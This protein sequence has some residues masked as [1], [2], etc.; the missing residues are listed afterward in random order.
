MTD[1]KKIM[2][3]IP[4]YDAKIAVYGM[5]SLISA[6][7]LLERNGYKVVFWGQLGCCYLDQT[8]NHI[9]DKFLASDCSH[10]I[11][12]DSDLSFDGDAIIKLLKADEQIVAAA[13]PYRSLEK[14]GFPISIKLDEN[15]IPIGNRE[16]HL[17]ECSF[18]PTGLMCIKRDVF[19]ILKKEYPDLIDSSGELQFFQT[20]ILFAK[21]GNKDY[22]GEDVYFCE[23][24]KRA[25]IQI[26]CDP[27]INIDH[28]GELHR[29]GNYD[30]YL[31]TAGAGNVNRKEQNGNRA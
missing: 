16:K 17:I 29:K 8:R 19:D 21:E 22:Y 28:I 5:F 15:R 12:V 1:P 25:G 23:I 3:A 11:M 7:I 30:Q 10:L 9:V 2:I 6:V 18:V 14:E 24:C 31:R 26:W 4:S 20:G 27:N 13:Y